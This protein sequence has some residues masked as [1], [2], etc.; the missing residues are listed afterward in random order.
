M[1]SLSY[2]TVSSR[3]PSQCEALD[4][5]PSGACG[6]ICLPSPVAL[7]PPA[8]PASVRPWTNSLPV[9]KQTCCKHM[10]FYHRTMQRVPRPSPQKKIKPTTLHNGV[11]PV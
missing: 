8:C 6:I 4:E 10:P 2:G 9:Q 7:C 11:P 3:L 5:F 1:P